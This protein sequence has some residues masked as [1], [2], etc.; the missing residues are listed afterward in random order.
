MPKNL[1]RIEVNTTFVK[2]DDAT[3]L[4]SNQVLMITPPLDERYWAF[5]VQLKHGQS[6][7]VFPKFGLLGCGFAVEK[8]W[9]TN[10]PINCEAEEIYAHIKHN[11]GHKDISRAECLAAIKDLQEFIK[12]RAANLK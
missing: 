1:N 11:K 4:N 9:N 5:R 2:A 8:D 3:N 6:I 12:D 7:V 10:L